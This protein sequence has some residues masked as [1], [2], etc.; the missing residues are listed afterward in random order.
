MPSKKGNIHTSFLHILQLTTP[1][2]PSSFPHLKSFSS[3]LLASITHFHSQNGHSSRPSSPAS[4]ISFCCFTRSYSSI[5]LVSRTRRS[6]N[7]GNG[8]LQSEECMQRSEAEWEP[9]WVDAY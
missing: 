5:S 7:S 9:S 3:S 1:Q 4:S 8:C 2:P 6:S